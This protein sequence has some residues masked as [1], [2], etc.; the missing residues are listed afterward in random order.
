MRV[1]YLSYDGMTDQLGQSQVLP[2]LIGLTS[3]GH[4]FTLISFEKEENFEKNKEEVLKIIEG[5]NIHWIPL[6]YTKKPPVLST[7]KDLYVLNK[8]V[9]KLHK[10]KR[11]DLVHCRSYI[12]ALIGLRLKKKHGVKFLFDMRGFYADERV[13]GGLWNLSNPL[14][15]N[16]YKFFKRKEKDFFQNADHIISLTSKGKQILEENKESS[17]GPISVIPCCAD[18]ELFSLTDSVQ[19]EK[20]RQKIGLR[21]EDLVVSYLGAIGT[22]YMLDEMLDFFHELLK[23]FPNAKFLFVTGEKPVNIL[24][25]ASEKNIPGENLKIIKVNRKEVP[26]YISISDFSIFFIKPVFSKMASSP[27]KLAE[28]MSMGIP[29]IANSG[30]GDVNEIITSSNAGILINGFS[31]A[32]YQ[33]T[34]RKIKELQTIDKSAIRNYAIQHFSLEKGVEKYEEVYE[35]MFN[36]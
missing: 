23:T 14:F 31:S 12:A 9:S 29:V 2:Y 7:L 24:S 19:K 32:E 30:V 26:D 21:K 16:I 3:Y 18:I 11:F 34:I 15:K 36:E 35:Q 1:L 13:D 5:L 17:L 27:T 4:Q 8:T 33:K 22:W 10:E 6:P 20:S 25:K 28:L